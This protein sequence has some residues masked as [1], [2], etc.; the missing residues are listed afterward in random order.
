MHSMSLLTG[1]AFYQLTFESLHQLHQD[2]LK[3]SFPMMTARN[4]KLPARNEVVF[5][6][7]LLICLFDGTRLI[8][9]PPS[10]ASDAYENIMSLSSIVLIPFMKNGMQVFA[11]IMA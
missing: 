10:S 6:E 3:F 2:E 5:R 4:A 11:R 1:Q 8:A 9:S 7:K